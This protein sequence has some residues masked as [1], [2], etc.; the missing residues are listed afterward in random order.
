MRTHAA[1]YIGTSAS[2]HEGDTVITVPCESSGEHS[3]RAPAGR[4]TWD[5]YITPVAARHHLNQTGA[6][7]EWERVGTRHTVT[8]IPCESSGEHSVIAPA[9]R[10]TWDPYVTPV[11]ARHHLNQTGAHVEWERVGTRHTVTTVPCESS[12][13]HSVIA[14]AGRP[15]WDPYVTPVACKTPFESNRSACR[16]GESGDQAHCDYGTM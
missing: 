15:T 5:P 8:T 12:G 10:P 13:E 1:Q 3:V 16:M 9:G 11:A 6:H 4:P 2:S 14:P 7:V